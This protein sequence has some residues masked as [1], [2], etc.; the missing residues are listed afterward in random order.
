MILLSILAVQPDW[1]RRVHH[2]SAAGGAGPGRGAHR[3][4]RQEGLQPPLHA[5][6][7]HVRRPTRHGLRLR[8]GEQCCTVIMYKVSQNNL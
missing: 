7:R 4:G 5:A 8:T 1:L 6:Q 2:P 3:Q